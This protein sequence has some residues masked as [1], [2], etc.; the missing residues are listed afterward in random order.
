MI[1]FSLAVHE[2]PEV[3]RNQVENFFHFNPGCQIVIHVSAWMP[4]TEFDVMRSLLADLPY[5]HI[6]D[7]RLWSGYGDGTQMKMHVVNFQYAQRARLN[8][9]YVC[10]HASNDMFVKHGLADHMGN[11]DA[12]FYLPDIADN[13]ER[14]VHMVRARKDPRLKK[15]MR[16]AGIKKIV[17]GQ[18]EGSFYNT[19]IMAEVVARI[20]K[21]AYYELPGIYAHGSSKTI[22]KF[23]GKK[24]V[25][26]VLNRLL[27]GIFYAKEELYF[28]T[29]SQ[30]LVKKRAPFNYLYVNWADNLN[31]TRQ[32]ID[33]IRRDDYSRLGGL[34]QFAL[35]YTDF[36]FFAVKRVDRKIDD[37]IR[38]YITSLQR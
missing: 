36:N 37:P 34:Q 21:S 17:G 27:K 23:T 30:D 12:G 28:P 4:A 33:D 25:R 32:D 18:V 2:K 3:V 9:R 15:A 11:Y 7:T 20:M 14:W 38:Q 8:F 5:V 6:N 26:A 35:K 1:L 31:I 16:K 13:D 24:T 22:T 19:A 10:L 29:L